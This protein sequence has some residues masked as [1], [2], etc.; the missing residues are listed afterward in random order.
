[1]ED[2]HATTRNIILNSIINSPVILVAWELVID[3]VPGGASI[4]NHTSNSG[5]LSLIVPWDLFSKFMQETWS[6]SMKI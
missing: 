5:Y 2:F 3:T 6:K 1:M 4:W